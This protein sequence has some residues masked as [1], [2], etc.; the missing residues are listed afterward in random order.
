M[1]EIELAAVVVVSIDYSDCRHIKE[2]I[3]IFEHRS[4]DLWVARCNLI[5]YL[6]SFLVAFRFVDVEF[7][8]MD[9]L[10]RKKLLRRHAARVTFRN[11]E[12]FPSSLHRF[13]VPAFFLGWVNTLFVIFVKLAFVPQRLNVLVHGGNT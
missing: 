5:Y 9:E 12:Y 4:Y 7:L 6:S 8:G 13:C 1:P 3:D 11:L 10:R 2:S